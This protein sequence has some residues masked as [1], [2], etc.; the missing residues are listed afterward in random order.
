[1]RPQ[2]V[3]SSSQELIESSGTPHKPNLLL[4][5]RRWRGGHTSKENIIMIASS[6]VV[7]ILG[8][9]GGAQALAE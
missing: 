9:D 4:E 5:P 1:M 8:V 6:N 7:S 2:D 3:Y